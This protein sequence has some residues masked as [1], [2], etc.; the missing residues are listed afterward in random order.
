MLG[1][2][3][4]QIIVDDGVEKKVDVLA[5]DIHKALGVQNGEDGSEYVKQVTL[6]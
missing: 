5:E 2:A 1:N 3:Y 6:L 4:H